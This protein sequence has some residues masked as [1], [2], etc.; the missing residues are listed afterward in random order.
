M[1]TEKDY[2]GDQLKERERAEEDRYFAELSKKQVER[3]RATHAQAAAAG[4][5]TCPRCGEALEVRERRG[6]AVDAC[7]QD[8]GLWL[9]KTELEEITKREGDSWLARL[10]LGSK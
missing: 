9:D 8:H 2:L 10:I 5:A 7:P 6:I 4:N 3:L 1:P